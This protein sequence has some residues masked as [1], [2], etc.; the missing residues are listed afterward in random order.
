MG[1]V[2]SGV[3]GEAQSDQVLFGICTQM[4]A[5]LLMMDLQIRHRSAGLT[6]PAISA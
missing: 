1:P 2:N 5:K 6:A 4:T 3:T